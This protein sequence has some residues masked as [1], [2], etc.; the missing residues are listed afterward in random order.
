M[1][2][3]IVTHQDN[4]LQQIVLTNARDVN[5]QW[6]V[7]GMDDSVISLTAREVY[8][9]D[10]FK[11]E[12]KEAWGNCW[13]DDNYQVNLSSINRPQICV[14][15][16][17]SKL[18]ERDFEKCWS[19]FFRELGE[20][21]MELT[22]DPEGDCKPYYFYRESENDIKMTRYVCGQKTTIL[23]LFKEDKGVQVIK[24]GG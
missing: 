7:T 1:S 18:N 2:N 19:E 4:T 11:Q 16:W 17:M 9:T 3:P 6:E 14:C 8:A 12:V 10:K 20:G 23:K 21:E 22:V 5:F 13:N 24:S 15:N